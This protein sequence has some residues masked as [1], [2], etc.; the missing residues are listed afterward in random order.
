MI[1]CGCGCRTPIPSA[2]G[3]RYVNHAHQQRA[4]RR[5]IAWTLTGDFWGRYRQL[6]RPK[7]PTLV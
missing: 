7:R 6:R 4:Y 5:R 1:L 3:R 2:G